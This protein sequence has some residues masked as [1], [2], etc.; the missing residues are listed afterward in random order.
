MPIHNIVGVVVGIA[1]LVFVL[2]GLSVDAPNS[3]ILF[4]TGVLLMWLSMLLTK[5]AG[6]PGL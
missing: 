2:F 6:D 5:A 4:S 1:S 3:F